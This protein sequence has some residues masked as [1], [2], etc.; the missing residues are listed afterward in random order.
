[1]WEQRKFLW[2]L[3]FFYYHKLGI[4]V[5]EYVDRMKMG[6]HTSEVIERLYF[7]LKRF[8]FF[9][10]PLTRKLGLRWYKNNKDNDFFKSDLAE[11]VRDLIKKCEQEG[12]IERNGDRIILKH[13][14]KYFVKPLYFY[15]AL[16]NKFSVL[17]QLIFAYG[18]IF[19]FS[20]LRIILDALFLWWFSAII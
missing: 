9:R 20:H 19:I 12:F 5:D 13:D 4:S 2:L 18:V 10:L 8:W 6:I 14:G 16:A 1:M 17:T 3:S 7:S 15:S 11:K